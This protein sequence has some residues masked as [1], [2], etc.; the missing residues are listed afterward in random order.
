M[1]DVTALDG[2][3][4]GCCAESMCWSIGEWSG[5]LDSDGGM[6]DGNYWAA[7]F[8]CEDGEYIN[9]VKLR[10]QLPQGEKDDSGTNNVRM[11]CTDGKVLNALT[12]TAEQPDTPDWGTWLDFESCPLGYAIS[13]L[14]VKIQK[15]QGEGD[16]TTINKIEFGCSKIES[17]KLRCSLITSCLHFLVVLV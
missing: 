5:D 6:P 14:R 16:D 15:D 1:T 4:V 9:T 8:S 11:K 3:F 10:S 2:F 13:S 17:G 12:F 7:S